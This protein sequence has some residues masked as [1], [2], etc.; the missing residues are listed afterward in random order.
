M[1]RRDTVPVFRRCGHENTDRPGTT[2]GKPGCPDRA[3]EAHGKAE[4]VHVWKRPCERARRE[5]RAHM[6]QRREV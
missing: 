3:L 2:S 1:S 4:R 6:W 5:A